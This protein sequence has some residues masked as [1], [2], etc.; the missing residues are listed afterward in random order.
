VINPKTPNK[1]IKAKLSSSQSNLLGNPIAKDNF[2]TIFG[3]NGVILQTQD[4][5]DILFTAKVN[6]LVF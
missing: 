2:D 5:L 3:V 4:T 6:D 1:T